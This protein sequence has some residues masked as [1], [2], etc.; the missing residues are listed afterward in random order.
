MSIHY[1]YIRRVIA[2]YTTLKFETYN[3][4]GITKRGTD[5]I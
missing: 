1:M 4:E 3:K 5:M 2:I